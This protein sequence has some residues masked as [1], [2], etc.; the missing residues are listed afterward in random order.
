MIG[1]VRNFRA[2]SIP[3]GS[4]LLREDDSCAH[5]LRGGA[6][7]ERAYRRQAITDRQPLASHLSEEVADVE[8]DRVGRAIGIHELQE[9]V[10][11]ALLEEE[12]LSV[13]L[14]PGVVRGEPLVFGRDARGFGPLVNDERLVD[15]AP[16]VSGLVSRRGARRLRI[17]ALVDGASGQTTA[18]QQDWNRSDGSLLL[19]VVD[20]VVS[21]DLVRGGG[22]SVPG[23]MVSG[24]SACRRDASRDED[25]RRSVV[26]CC[27]NRDGIPYRGRDARSPRTASVSRRRVARISCPG[28]ARA[29]PLWRRPCARTSSGR[30]GSGRGARPT[31]RRRRFG[32]TVCLSV[33][34]PSSD[35]PH[36]VGRESRRDRDGCRLRGSSDPVHHKQ[37][38]GDPPAIGVDQGLEIGGHPDL[39]DA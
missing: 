19:S 5:G 18:E 17:G 3:C 2:A 13:H 26:S 39:V 33:D 38:G 6:I 32:Q 15:G 9:V 8:V 1:R 28:M 10:G 16:V 34:R 14:V 12:A 30:R 35:P 11:P 31:P 25:A 7:F 29:T 23:T 36:R 37:V 27:R 20:T 21:G 4:H 22:I 24:A